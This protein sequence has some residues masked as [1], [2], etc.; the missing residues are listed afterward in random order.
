VQQ[1]LVGDDHPDFRFVYSLV[2]G[3]EISLEALPEPMK[4]LDSFDMS[5]YLRFK[6][7][8]VFQVSTTQSRR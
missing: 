5:S 2:E 7:L 3:D 1:I 4:G 6:K 8:P